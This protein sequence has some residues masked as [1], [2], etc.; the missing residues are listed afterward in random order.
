[1]IQAI[2][3]AEQKWLKALFD[4]NQSLFSSHNIPSHNQHH[5]L[6]V[7]NYLKD[8]LQQLTALGYV[9][10]QNFAEQALIAT[11]FHDTGLTKTLDEKHGMESREICKLFFQSLPAPAN[12]SGILDAIEHHDD[13]NYTIDYAF[14]KQELSLHTLLSICDDLDAF[15]EIGIFRYMEIYLM[16]E[17]FL[18]DITL[19]ICNNMQKRFLHFRQHF[20]F[21]RDFYAFHQKRYEVSF[22]F[23]SKLSHKSH[24]QFMTDEN[25]ISGFLQLATSS[26]LIKN[27]NKIS[28]RGRFY[29]FIQ[30][31]LQE[32]NKKQIK[33]LQ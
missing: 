8:L 17:I 7:W 20:R 27:I 5:H 32:L 28:N 1:M 10:P 4:Y 2:E 12:F 25:F 30:K 24:S 29:L 16:R 31:C 21:L 22:H 11:F 3:K 26:M 6:R 15:G 23:F 18:K 14:A 19:Q 9:F 13:K 33:D